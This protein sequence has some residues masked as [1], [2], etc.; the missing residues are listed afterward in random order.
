MY[1]LQPL[2]YAQRILDG[3][4]QSEE[5]AGFDKGHTRLA[6]TPAA[7]SPTSSPTT[8]TTGAITTFKTPSV[9]SRPGQALLNAIA[10]AE[11]PM[12][13]VGGLVHGTTVA[14]N[15]LIERTG[16]RVGFLV[17]AGHEDI[18]YIQRI[19]RKTLYDLFW[20]KPKPLLTSRRDSLGV[21]ERLGLRR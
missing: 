11:S 18:P 4:R 6:S 12:A 19:N 21:P 9:P 14:T 15:A 2:G 17:T 3:L 16:A 5:H 13:G 1:G 7:P 20:Q 10:G 8:R